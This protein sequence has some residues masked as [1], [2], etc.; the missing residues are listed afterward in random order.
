MEEIEEIEEIETTNSE[1]RK[2]VLLDALKK[3]DPENYIEMFNEMMKDERTK[4]LVSGE[5]E[6][7]L[8]NVSLFF[9]EEDYP[10]SGLSPTQKEIDSKDSI[11]YVLKN[12]DEIDK[13]FTN[14]NSCYIKYP[15]VLLNR[16]FIMDGHHR[17]AQMLAINPNVYAKCYRFSSAKLSPMGLIREVQK[18]RDVASPANGNPKKI[19]NGENLLSKQKTKKEIIDYINEVAVDKEKIL[20]KLKTYVGDDEIENWEDAVDYITDNL[21]MIRIDYQTFQNAPNRNL[22]S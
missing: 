4:M 1:E 17:W 3:L 21:I 13:L 7:K 2:K 10:V 20:D 6:G 8:K 14:E 16:L 11:D 12:P 18:A 9:S 22:E 5:F 19:V 15:L